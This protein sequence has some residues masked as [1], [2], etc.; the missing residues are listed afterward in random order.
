MNPHVPPPES[1][2]PIPVMALQYS[3]LE[4]RR[5][6]A[7]SVIAVIGI[8]MASLGFIVAAF[9]VITAI[10]TAIMGRAMPMMQWQTS[11]VM[12]ATI[13]EA[14]FGA[15]LAA[16]LMT[17]SI[18]LL[19]LRSWSRRVLIWWGWIY[20]AGA[21][22]FLLL[23]IVIVVPSQV[24]M[25]TKM[26]AAMPPAP[27]A[28][29]PVVVATTTSGGATTYTYSSTATSPSIAPAMAPVVSGM[30]KM[31][32]IA[33]AIGKSVISLI[34]PIAVLIVMQLRNVR[35]ALTPAGS[36]V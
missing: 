30:M 28:T 3:S 25:V 23:Q 5:P 13:C 15:A 22:V 27:P 36:S 11:S 9:G 19:R 17:G 18:G 10:S 35:S 21:A 14:V 29:M 34:F 4:S 24:T 1:V 6:T 12:T 7:V 8:V 31:G 20:L 2:P 33:M 26:M 32:Y 16:A